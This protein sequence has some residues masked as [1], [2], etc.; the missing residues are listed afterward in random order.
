MIPQRDL[1]L[2]SNSLLKERG[3]RRIPDQTIELDYVLGWF[4]CEMSEHSFSSSLAFKGRTALRR[5]YFGEYRFSEDLD[6]TLLL[7]VTFQKIRTA[8][9]EIAASVQTKTGMPFRFSR[10]DSQ[11]HANSHTFYMA[12]TG[13]MRREREFKVDVTKTEVITDGLEKLQIIKTYPEFDF[14]DHGGLPVYSID[15]I[16]TEKIV[17]LTDPKRSQPRD[18]FDIWTLVEERDLDLSLLG[19]AIAQKL[20][21]RDRSADGMQDVFDKK[22][23]ILKATWNSP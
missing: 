4:L 1:S 18:L 16:T 14:P 8:F 13:P 7:E 12:Y 9:E 6:F 19:D 20:K 11:N 21:F 5:C 2:I 10:E 3:G 23:K 22:E 15:E 17:A